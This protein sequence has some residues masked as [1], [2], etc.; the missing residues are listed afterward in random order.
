MTSG[1]PCLA[2]KA[3]ERTSFISPEKNSQLVIPLLIALVRASS[4]ASG[5]YSMLCV[6]GDAVYPLGFEV[7]E[8]HRPHCRLGERPSADVMPENPKS[9]IGEQQILVERKRGR[10]GQLSP[11]FPPAGPVGRKL[12]CGCRSDAASAFAIR[13]QDKLCIGTHERMV[14]L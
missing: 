1:C 3:G 5:T 14:G 9:Q 8:C 12:L 7:C 6:R 10:R 13:H 4:I 2:I 11:G